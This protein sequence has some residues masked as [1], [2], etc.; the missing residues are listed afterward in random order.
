MNMRDIDTIT[1]KPGK[2]YHCDVPATRT[3]NW[4]DHK[5]NVWY[6]IHFCPVHIPGGLLVGESVSLQSVGIRTRTI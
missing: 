2:C 1:I 5:S 6:R 4:Y 3:F